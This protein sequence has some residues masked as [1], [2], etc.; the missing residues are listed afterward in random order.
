[1]GRPNFPIPQDAKLRAMAF[2]KQFGVQLPILEAPM[3]GAC[4]VELAVA[5]AEGGGMGA[6][7]A[8]LSSPKTITEWAAEFRSRTDGPFQLNLW[9]PDPAPVRDFVAE[10]RVREF[11]SKW[12]PIVSAEAGEGKLPD[13]E[14]QCAA[15]IDIRPTVVS[16]IMGLYPPAVVA[17]L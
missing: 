17:K 13:F 11:L 14:D 4:P 6:M 10:E 12:G 3:A 9:I 1:M 2:C 15:F 5:V 8:L 7:G 16:S